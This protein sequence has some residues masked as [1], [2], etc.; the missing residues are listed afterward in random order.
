M[1]SIYFTNFIAQYKEKSVRLSY[2]SFPLKKRKRNSS[3]FG[4]RL[5]LPLACSMR[6][7]SGPPSS[8]CRLSEIHW[9]AFLTFSSSGPTPVIVSPFCLCSRTVGFLPVHSSAGLPTFHHTKTIASQIGST[10]DRLWDVI[11]AGEIQKILFPF[12][13]KHMFLF[14]IAVFTGCSN[15]VLSTPAAADNWNDVIHGQLIWRKT[16]SAV[17][18]SASGQSLLPPPRFTQGPGLFPLPLY[19]LF[20]HRNY[21]RWFHKSPA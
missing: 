11:A 4:E 3:S 12:H 9:T 14:I 16:P 2:H 7:A 18:A 15:V 1:Q 5:N 13:G 6:E 20:T 8:Y 21:K 19:L 10:A 17:I